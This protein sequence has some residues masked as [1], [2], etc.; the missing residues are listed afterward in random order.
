MARDNSPKHPRL[1]TFFFFCVLM[2]TPFGHTPASF[3]HMP[4]APLTCA[5]LFVRQQMRE[6]TMDSDNMMNKATRWALVPG[7]LWQSLVSG[8][9]SLDANE[10]YEAALTANHASSSGWWIKAERQELYITAST[11]TCFG[12][13]ATL[14]SRRFHFLALIGLALFAASLFANQHVPTLQFI[15]CCGIALF[16]LQ[17]RIP[18]R[19][20]TE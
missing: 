6:K 7:H 17:G 5:G 18:K 12:A 14:V 16:D 2:N 11:C 19:F 9:G 13:V 15:V 4:V 10:L 1:T 8:E 3:G 20:R